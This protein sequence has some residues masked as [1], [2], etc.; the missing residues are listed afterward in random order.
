MIAGSDAVQ[1]CKPDIHVSPPVYRRRRAFM[2]KRNEDDENTH[3]PHYD[4][5]FGEA[6]EDDERDE[7]K[8]DGE[9]QCTQEMSPTSRQRWKAEIQRRRRG[10]MLYLTHDAL[11]SPSVLFQ[12]NVIKACTMLTA[13]VT[14]QYKANNRSSHPNQLAL[15]PHFLPLL[16]H[17]VCVPPKVCRSYCSVQPTVVAAVTNNNVIAHNNNNRNDTI[18][19]IDNS[20]DSANPAPAHSPEEVAQIV[21]MRTAITHSHVQCVLGLVAS[22]IKAKTFYEVTQLRRQIVNRADPDDAGTT[23]LYL[24]ARYGRVE[25]IEALVRLGANVEQGKDNGTSPLHVAALQ[26]FVDCVRLLLGYGADPNALIMSGDN[27]GAT[28]IAVAAKNSQAECIELLV[29]RGGNVATPLS[30][31]TTPLYLAAQSGSQVCVDLLIQH[32]QRHELSDEFHSQNRKGWFATPISIAA[33][34]GHR[35]CLES[36]LDAGFDVNYAV[37][38]AAIPLYI[39]TQRRHVA[40]VELL[41]QRGA[42]RN[43]VIERGWTPLSIAAYLGDRACVEVLARYDADVNAV[44]DNAQRHS[45]LLIAAHN[46]HVSVVEVLVQYGAQLNTSASDGATAVYVAA[47]QGQVECLRSLITLGADCNV[48]NSHG[49]TPLYI[50]V[51]NNHV[52]VVKLLIELGADVNIPKANGVTPLHMAA[53]QGHTECLI[54]LVC[55][56]KA[57]IDP[58]SSVDGTPLIAAVQQGHAACVDV[59]AKLG[60]NINYRTH[61]TGCSAVSI[62]RANGHTECEQR[63]LALG[64]QPDPPT[65]LKHDNTESNPERCDSEPE[66]ANISSLHD[67]RMSENTMLEKITPV[68]KRRVKNK[69]RYHRRPQH[70]LKGNET[71]AEG[72]DLSSVSEAM[73][74]MIGKRSRS[75]GC[76]ARRRKQREVQNVAATT[77][78]PST[79]GKEFPEARPIAAVAAASA[80]QQSAPFPSN[81][82]KKWYRHKKRYG[83]SNL[84][85]SN[86]TVSA[87]DAIGAQTTAPAHSSAPA[88][89]S[90]ISCTSMEHGL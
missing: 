78:T 28:P 37:D 64:A 22:E 4:L 52:E 68:R 41:A 81:G 85:A 84:A 53:Y 57:D 58:D 82:R 44:M 21:R 18:I 66:P 45:P 40:C 12:E 35:E 75:H 70:Q 9:F 54:A 47:Q 80:N 59:L 73:V 34:H 51:Q 89:T 13:A 38:G 19:I 50:A 31:G 8:Y 56:G 61:R 33:Y 7:E 87:A 1:I 74:T 71:S 79:T 27:A 77:T 3:S 49:A 20:G 65:V 24:A 26:G 11:H 5:Y 90:S 63:L 6:I 62:A 60:A 32:S 42:D 48:Q 72:L 55:E 76:Q 10:E 2:K 67:G 86:I 30:D 15:D 17:Q 69:G 29:K 43:A 23:P 39:A 16:M 25:C 36:L 14:S 46:G 83:K 88:V